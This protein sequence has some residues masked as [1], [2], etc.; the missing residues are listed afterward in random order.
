MGA[1]EI[2]AYRLA[3]SELIGIPGARDS[4]L[5]VADT[6]HGRL[7]ACRRRRHESNSSYVRAVTSKRLGHV[8]H[9]LG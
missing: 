1:V 9:L 6:Y 8:H 7:P 4:S 5:L 3:Q 2:L